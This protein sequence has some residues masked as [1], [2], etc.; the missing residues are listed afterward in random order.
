MA[1]TVI[2]MMRIDYSDN[3]FYDDDYYDDDDGHCEILTMMILV[4]SLSAQGSN[5][6]SFITASVTGTRS[7][8]SAPI[9]DTNA[10]RSARASN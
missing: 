8:T 1:M 5:H 3:N 10:A 4:Q 9:C 7:G 6:F 2:I